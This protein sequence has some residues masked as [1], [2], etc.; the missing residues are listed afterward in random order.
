MAYRYKKGDMAKLRRAKALR[1]REFYNLQSILSYNWAFYYFLLG[2]R[3]AGKS[4]ATMDFFLNQW[5]KYKRPFYWLRLT[6]TQTKGLLQ[7]NADKLIDTSLRLKYGLDITT[8]NECVYEVLERDDKGKILKKEL[9]CRVLALNTFYNDKGKALYD[10]NFLKD[11]NMYYNIC[12]DEMNR[13][14]GERNTFD[15]LNAFS[16]QIENLIRTTEPEK[17]RI[18]CIGNLIAGCDILSSFNF[19]PIKPGRYK[20]RNRRAVVEYMEQTEPQKSKRANAASNYLTPDASTFTNEVEY[21][22]EKIRKRE[23]L[24]R[25]RRIIAFGKK[26]NEWFV[27]WEGQQGDRI[28]KRYSG[29]KIPFIAMRSNMDKFFDVSLRK[30]IIDIFN[31]RGFCYRDLATQAQFINAIAPLLQ[32]S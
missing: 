5:R 23:R 19:I 27:E 9:M 17:V 4:Y 21:D 24:I 1:D 14:K 6:D 30:S 26:T 8:R 13:E 7:N 20:L 10:F 28:I 32:N 3:C 11:P 16:N 12:L 22:I 15:I 29:E 2:A 31:N 25:P 18:I